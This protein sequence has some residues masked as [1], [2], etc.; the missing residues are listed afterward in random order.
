MARL[1]FL[2]YDIGAGEIIL[3]QS[4]AKMSHNEI[5]VLPNRITERQGARLK[6]RLTD[7]FL[8]KD[9]KPFVSEVE[10]EFGKIFSVCK[11]CGFVTDRDK[12]NKAWGGLCK[13]CFRKHQ[14][15]KKREY[16][17][18]KDY[19]KKVRRLKEYIKTSQGR[20]DAVPIEVIESNIRMEV[21][22][23]NRTMRELAGHLNMSDKQMSVLFE[24]KRID[25]DLL[26]AI[27]EHLTTPM[28]QMLRLPRGF[29]L[30]RQNGLPGFWF[31]DDFRM[32]N[33]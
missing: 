28:E 24:N 21:I 16:Q 18:N 33:E 31:E 7:R 4:K 25:F 2:K 23:Q 15:E 19:R 17:A 1:F 10:Y 13:K 27:C 32:K 22:R 26:Q 5:L 30:K 29:R 20:V 11:S 6:E 12:T 14:E 9:R 8:Y 3:D